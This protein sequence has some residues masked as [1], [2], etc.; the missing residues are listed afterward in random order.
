MK[1]KKQIVWILCFGF[2]LS[3][4]SQQLNEL[5]DAF[6]ST[7]GP[8][9]KEKAL[10]KLTGEERFNFNFVPI[11][12]KGPTFH[13]FNEPQKAAALRLLKASLSK[14]GYFKATEI[15]ALEYVLL[16]LENDR[17]KMPDGSSMRDALNYHFSIFGQPGTDNFWGWRFEGHHLS[18][19]FVAS[20]G[21]IKS[22]T[23]SFMG[24]NPGIV[25]SGQQK[26]K[27]VLKLETQL[28]FEF[29]NSLSKEQLLMARFSETAPSEIM[30]R[31]HPV[32]HPLEH[33][34][35]SY[36]S[37]SAAQ[38]TTFEKLLDVYL[39][40]YES[41]FSKSFRSKIKAAGF[42]QLSF[43]WAGGLQEGTGHYYSIQG[44]VLLIE[45]DNTQNN[46]NHVHSVVRDLTNDFGRDILQEHYQ[47]E[48]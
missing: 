48:H 20:K 43:A 6:L 11:V 47:Q 33:H 9:L 7:L 41:E 2:A 34:G 1:L 8:E 27:Q 45:Y 36:P 37:L 17:H 16:D 15:I 24:S 14:K 25:P 4:T 38:K 42:D 28:A 35:I 22:S 23:P 19:N 12:R 21:V 5:A 10:F 32:V 18:L 39:D 44:P 40:N 29:V 26:G 46:A 13:D 31:N 30:T 3:A